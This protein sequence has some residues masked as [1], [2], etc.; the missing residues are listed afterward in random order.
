MSFHLNTLIS[1]YFAECDLAPNYIFIW[2]VYL[3]TLCQM[4]DLNNMSVEEDTGYV[5]T[6]N[7]AHWQHL[8][9]P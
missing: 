5:L 9:I 6:K 3:V 4:N 7:I 2:D 8:H 1:Y